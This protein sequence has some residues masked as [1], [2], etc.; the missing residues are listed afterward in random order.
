MNFIIYVM[1]ICES[2]GSLG[3][4]L[5]EYRSKYNTKGRERKEKG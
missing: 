2:Q 4:Y 5:A 1:N 3:Q